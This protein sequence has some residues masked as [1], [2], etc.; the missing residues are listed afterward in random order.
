[1]SEVLLIKVNKQFRNPIEEDSSVSTFCGRGHELN[2]LKYT[3]IN[4]SSAAILISGVRGVGK[5]SF[6][7]ES[8]RQLKNDKTV[9]DLTAAHISFADVD[10]SDPKQL[11]ERVLKTL[12]RSLYFALNPEER[13]EEEVTA[14]YDK[15]YFSSLKS[16]GLLEL[17]TSKESEE[18][19]ST[20]SQQKISF[21]VTDSI[22]QLA[23]LV[24]GAIF[25]LGGL[26]FTANAIATHSIGIGVVAIIFFLAILAA[27]KLNVT[28]ITSTNEENTA[29]D[30]ITAKTNTSKSAVY[31]LS[32]DALEIQ[33]EQILVTLAAKGK[34][35]VFVIDELDKLTKEPNT[36][37]IFEVVRPL[38]NLFN[39]SKSIF[40]FVGADDFYD[41]LEMERLNSPYS[42]SHTL[43]TDRIFLS[44]LY[45]D[46]V[47][48]LIDGYKEELKKG[49]DKIYA[50]FK[51]YI[52]WEARNHVFDVHRLLDDFAQ[53][54]NSGDEM[55]LSVVE[56]DDV[57]RGNIPDNWEVAAGLQVFIATTFDYYRRTGANRFSEKLFLTLR[58]VAQIY[59][60]DYEISVEDNNYLGILPSETQEKLKIT[61]TYLLDNE[62]KDLEGAIEDFLKRML[63]VEETDFAAHTK[64][65]K[66]DQTDPSKS[67]EIKVDY[68]E[69]MDTAFPDEQLIRERNK[70]LSFEIEFLEI[71]N[72]LK[73]MQKN[74]KAAGWDSG[75]IYDKEIMTFSR[76]ADRISKE[77]KNRETKSGVV[78]MIEDIA[79]LQDQWQI[80]IF[81]DL[82][83]RTTKEMGVNEDSLSD[84]S[85][86][87]TAK[88][89]LST[90]A[91]Y[92]DYLK[93]NVN[94]S[95]FGIMRKDGK[96]ALLQLNFEPEQQDEYLKILLTDRRKASFKCINII[97]TL[98]LQATKKGQTKWV[99]ETLK[100]DF[101]DLT[102][103]SNRIKRH[104][105]VAFG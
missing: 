103:L 30:E 91:S 41:H 59:Y 61:E 73:E 69:L 46:E 36:Q 18:K 52:S 19:K 87:E 94:E 1:M 23:R 57:Q 7:R 78:K 42:S 26:S 58:A 86:I 70:K 89:E 27:L 11:R 2:R 13:K 67:K 65:T 44:T 9:N 60:E 97:S 55:L 63:R 48:Q 31:D 104:L 102:S 82:F 20:T 92:I 5:T 68:Y 85:L 77:Q 25:A 43:F 54:G 37:P 95:Y 100:T 88:S 83:K 10:C 3:I 64:K 33:L 105:S 93:G 84:T 50:Q 29:R 21:S 81:E 53:Y 72:K 45:H 40:I 62:R 51:A 38:K 35:I 34:K 28:N 47:K 79:E 6:V 12:I 15:T 80:K 76:V 24:L 99:E 22:V 101:S 66:T 39:L 74:V 98:G 32:A 90:I 75:A 8:L 4:R 16:T 56:K 17:A 49:N 71:F 96:W 14:L